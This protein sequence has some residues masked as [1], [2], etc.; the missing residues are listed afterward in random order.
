MALS[1]ASGHVRIFEL[2]SFAGELLLGLRIG[3]LAGTEPVASFETPLDRP[4]PW[5]HDISIHWTVRRRADG[6]LVCMG[7]SVPARGRLVLQRGGVSRVVSSVEPDTPDRIEVITL[8]APAWS[9]EIEQ[10]F[11]EE[12]SQ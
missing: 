3:V 10:R 9:A 2:E 4:T 12:V 6:L 8:I 7:V 1:V 5:G 11:I